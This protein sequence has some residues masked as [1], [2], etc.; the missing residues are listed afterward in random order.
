M[1]KPRIHYK[2]HVL[3]TLTWRIIG[4][5]DT[6]L[7]GWFVSGDPTIGLSIGGI[8]VFTKMLLYFF[9]ERAWYKLTDFG[10]EK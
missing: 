10:E 8:E 6:I 5:I 9:H 3:K 4:T 2:R 1:S 7:I